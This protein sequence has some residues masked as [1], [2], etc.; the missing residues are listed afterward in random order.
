MCDCFDKQPGRLKYVYELRIVESTIYMDILY[1]VTLT[2][3][4][5][6]SNNLVFSNTDTESKTSMVFQSWVKTSLQYG[7]C[8]S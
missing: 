2:G 7:H 4:M 5:N 8:N 3:C 1:R 6:Q